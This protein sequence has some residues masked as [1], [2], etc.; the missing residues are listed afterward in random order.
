MPS[1]DEEAA[2][3]GQYYGHFWSS[4]N[5]TVWLLLRDLTQGTSRSAWSVVRPFQQ[6]Y[7]GRGS[8]LAM[9]AMYMGNNVKLILMKNAETTL[10]NAVYDGQSEEYTWTKHVALLREVSGQAF[11]E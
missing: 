9:R 3:R 6:A 7:N 1:F 10:A 2:A 4:D 11:T 8:Y 5:K